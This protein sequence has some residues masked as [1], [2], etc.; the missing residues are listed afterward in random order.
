MKK[1]SDNSMKT[2]LCML[3][4]CAVLTAL[5]LFIYNSFLKNSSDDYRNSF[6]TIYA[7]ALGGFCT[8]FGVLLTAVANKSARKEDIRTQCI[9][10]FFQPL[11]YDISTAQHLHYSHCDNKNNIISNNHIYLKNTDKNEFTINE[12]IVID[13]ANEY[14]LAGNEYY[15]DKGKLFCICFY[16]DKRIETIKINTTSLDNNR[17][18]YCVDLLKKTCVREGAKNDSK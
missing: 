3:L 4:L 12:I 9:P 14:H 2:V 1:N 13:D 17:Y 7:G 11:V 6:I 8:L 5:G 15:I 10:E 18:T 16:Y